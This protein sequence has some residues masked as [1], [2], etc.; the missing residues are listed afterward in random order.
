VRIAKKEMLLGGAI[1]A[2]GWILI[3][4]PVALAFLFV[5]LYGVTVVHLDQWEIIPLFEKLSLGTLAVSDLFAPHNQHRMFFPWIAMLGL[6]TITKYNNVAEMYFALACFLGML[7]A[8]F[9]VFRGSIKPRLP[10]LL[11]VFFVPIAFLVLSL[12][13]HE[14]LLW[15][16]QLAFGLVQVSSVLALC[17][18]YFSGYERLRKLV[19]PAALTSCTVAT[20]SALQGLM[21]WPVGLLQL[22]IGPVEK[23]TK[24]WLVGA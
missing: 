15:G 20:F 3:L 11:P 7:T 5:Y 12:S 19:F 21:V 10:F 23:P 18:L 8:L 17:L 9:L 1:W 4:L 14:N 2:L 24:K 16:F 13:Q 22:L 6:G